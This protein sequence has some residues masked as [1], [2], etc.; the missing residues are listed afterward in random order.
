MKPFF[1]NIKKH[2]PKGIFAIILIS[3]FLG[4]NAIAQDRRRDGDKREGNQ[5][6][7]QGGDHHQNTNRGNQARPVTR[8]ADNV[9]VNRVNRNTTINRTTCLLYTSPSPRD[10]LLS[11]M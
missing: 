1:T 2:L 8:P 5:G 10:G 7:R 11:R 4:G 3:T 9:R 6:N